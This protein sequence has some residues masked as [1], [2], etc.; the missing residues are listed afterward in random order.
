MSEPSRVDC[1]LG[2]LKW[3]IR[4]VVPTSWAFGTEAPVKTPPVRVYG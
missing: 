2:P 1:P 4:P 3:W